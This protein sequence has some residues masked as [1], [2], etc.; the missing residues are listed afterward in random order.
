MSF[1]KMKNDLLAF[2]YTNYNNNLQNNN[3]KNF[4]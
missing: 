2:G 4:R 1:Y 3:L